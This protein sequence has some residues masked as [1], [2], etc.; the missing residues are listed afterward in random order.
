MSVSGFVEVEKF[1]NDQRVCVIEY[2][3]REEIMCRNYYTISALISIDL[4]FLYTF[5]QINLIT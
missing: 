1:R 3:G 4:L 5:Y 2:R